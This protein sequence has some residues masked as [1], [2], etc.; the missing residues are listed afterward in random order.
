MIFKIYRMLLKT[1]TAILVTLLLSMI[2]ISVVQIVMRNFFTSG[3][4]WADSFVRIAVL[5]LAL[6]GAMV[7][8][9]QGRHIT[10][11][12]LLHLFSKRMQ[13][14]VKRLTDTFTACVCFVV[15]YYS[16]EFV[17]IE[18]E[19]AGLAFAFVPNWLCESIIPFAFFI[20]GLRYIISALFNL[21]HK[22]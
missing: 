7:A 1:E 11:E 14:A 5:W 2:V 21:R 19:D 18:Y 10:I 16:F 15:A 4:I 3:L 8:S 22:V 12:V 9:R 6:I 17:K 13:R 20:I